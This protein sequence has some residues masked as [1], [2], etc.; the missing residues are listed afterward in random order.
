MPNCL[1]P[2]QVHSDASYLY[3][4]SIAIMASCSDLTKIEYGPNPK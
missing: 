2:K 3:S 4:S 1:D